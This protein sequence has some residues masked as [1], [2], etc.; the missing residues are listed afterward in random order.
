MA[1]GKGKV[2]F[3]KGGART[4]GLTGEQSQA[5]AKDRLL[6]RPLA[7]EPEVPDTPLAR[8]AVLSERIKALSKPPEPNPYQRDFHKFLTTLCYTKDEARAGKVAKMPDYPYFPELCDALMTCH[9]LLI[10][11]ARRVLAS[12][13]VCCFDLWLIGGG[14]DPRW[15]GE[16]TEE[17]PEGEPVL[18]STTENRKVVIAAAALEGEN[19]SAG[20]LSERIKFVY[21]EFE[22]R[23]FR[24]QYWPEFPHI[25][26]KYGRAQAS[27]GGVIA[28]IAQGKDKARGLAATLVHVEELHTWTEARETIGT[29]M[30]ALRPT[31]HMVAITTA[32]ANTFASRI[33]HGTLG[34]MW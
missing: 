4:P 1:Q 3:P 15:R 5:I 33:V 20:Y 13:V 21:D 10:D 14:Q 6:G 17:F 19:G 16:P 27:N 24:E 29:I 26:W 31:G 30:P 25:E 9:P 32:R 28:A 7:P 12:W 11:K 34:G 2:G 18:M 8:L 22:A 23:G